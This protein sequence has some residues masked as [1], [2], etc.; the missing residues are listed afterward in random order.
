MSPLKR[1]LGAVAVI[2]LRSA[3]RRFARGEPRC[4]SFVAYLAV[5]RLDLSPGGRCGSGEKTLF[6]KKAANTNEAG[7]ALELMVR[8]SSPFPSAYAA[9]R[10]AVMGY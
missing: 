2:L 4:W 10:R 6:G 1:A 8:V 9:A 5:G 3:H 7:I